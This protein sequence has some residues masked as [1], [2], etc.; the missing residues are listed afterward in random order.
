MN[1]NLTSVRTYIRKLYK[2]YDTTD[3]KKMWV[4]VPSTC[5]SRIDKENV[6]YSTID[7]LERNIKINKH[8]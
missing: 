8:E 1:Q 7:F 6:I 4:R 5:V 3:R 2:K